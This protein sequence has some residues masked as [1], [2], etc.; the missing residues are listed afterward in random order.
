MLWHI[1]PQQE[2]AHLVKL[3]AF[4]NLYSADLSADEK[5]VLMRRWQ[6]WNS[7]EAPAVA[8]D[9]L[10]AGGLGAVRHA[11]QWCTSLEKQNNLAELLV[12]FYRNW[13]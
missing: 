7:A 8:G 4:L 13:V 6:S 3:A 12:Q 5:A 9:Q 1:Y 11:E 2:D 10:F